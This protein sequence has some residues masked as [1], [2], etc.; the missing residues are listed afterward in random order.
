MVGLRTVL[1]S[2]IPS[3]VIPLPGN[4]AQATGPPSSP[5]DVFGVDRVGVGDPGARFCQ[6]DRCI[7]VQH[8]VHVEIPVRNRVALCDLETLDDVP[9]G[10]V[11]DPIDEKRL[12]HDE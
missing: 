12:L 5:N 2:L 8:H 6:L 1:G 3:D 7:R 4:A 11:V 9:H 10:L